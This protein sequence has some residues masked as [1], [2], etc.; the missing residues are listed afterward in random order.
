MT[1]RSYDVNKILGLKNSTRNRSNDK[2]RKCC[3]K[4]SIKRSEEIFRKSSPDTSTIRGQHS[5]Y[6]DFPLGCSH[7]EIELFVT[8]ET[9][10][11]VSNYR[12]TSFIIHRQSGSSSHILSSVY[13]RIP[14]IMCIN[15]LNGNKEMVRRFAVT[16]WM[17]TRFVLRRTS[18]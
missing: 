14:A 6:L 15:I 9:L 4:T 17:E 3:I 11:T 16:L 7:F 10:E 8:K 13:C 5:N 2:V 12:P 1:H 18:V